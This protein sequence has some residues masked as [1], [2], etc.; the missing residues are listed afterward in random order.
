MA[1]KTQTHPVV[2]YSEFSGYSR[3]IKVVVEM[4]QCMGRLAQDTESEH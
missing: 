2:H 1:Q 3:N 4:Q